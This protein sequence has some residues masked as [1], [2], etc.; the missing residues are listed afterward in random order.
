MDRYRLRPTAGL[1]E[2]QGCGAAS[3][4]YT[5]LLVVGHSLQPVPNATYGRAE[6]RKVLPETVDILVEKMEK[7][8]SFRGDQLRWTI[9]GEGTRRLGVRGGCDIYVGIQTPRAACSGSRIAGRYCATQT[10]EWGYKIAVE[11]G[12][13]AIL[14]PRYDKKDICAFVLEQMTGI[15]TR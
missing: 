14:L 12:K 2:E 15:S 5:R 7:D 9:L 10:G 13:L 3:A 4:A 6:L 8:I 1:L 11:A